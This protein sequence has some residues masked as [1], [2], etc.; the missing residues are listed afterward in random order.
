MSVTVVAH[1]PVSDVAKAIEGLQGHASL[2][3]EMT[4]A[5]KN[6]GSLGHRVFAGDGELV[7]IDEWGTVEQFQSF[8]ADNAN[9]G[10]ISSSLG[11]MGPPALSV[12]S[13]VDVPGSFFGELPTHA[14]K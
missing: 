10:Q 4:A 11:V 3:E 2:L 12:L 6:S 13:S 14:Q 1:F 5:N 7:I 9:V 8:I